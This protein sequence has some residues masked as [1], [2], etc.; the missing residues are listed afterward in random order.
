LTLIFWAI[1]PPIYRQNESTD[2][3]TFYDPIANRLLEG[4]GYT[5]PNG[6]F[7]ARYPPGYPIIL[8]GIYGAAKW[9]TLPK[10]IVLSIFI[11]VV[12]GLTSVVLFL[13]TNEVLGKTSGIIT[14]I[15]WM[16]YP[17]YLWIT[18]QPNSEIIF[19]LFLYTS[20]LIFWISITNK[21]KKWYIF[22]LIGI[23]TGISTLIRPASLGLILIMVFFI[24]L[25]V[26]TDLKNK[27]KVSISLLMGFILI[28]LPWEI[29]I[30][31]NMSKII[32]MS[33]NGPKTI[34]LGLTYAVIDEGFRSSDD[35]QVDED[36]QE[37]MIRYLKKSNEDEL[38]SFGGISKELINETLLH[39]VT[40]SKIFVYKTLRSWYATDSVR[41]ETPIIL[42]QIVY[43]SFILLGAISL[44]IYGGIK[45]FFM[46]FIL[47]IMI[48]FWLI[49]I[50]VISLVRYM[51]PVTGLLFT[52]IPAGRLFLKNKILTAV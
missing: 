21:R 4:K 14:S 37:F 7:S 5:L 3:F 23:I 6:S 50:S 8:A 25:G 47:S 15:L 38:Q 2:F 31:R 17:L 12:V 20:I 32:L 18:K 48:Y 41:W 39:P 33:T 44:W 24:L 51:V 19:I 9:F 26:K 36:V 40:I 43:L 29:S 45:R 28:I 42:I 13:L 49:T 34:N 11:L 16:T 35:Y 52:F 22:V 1:L 27:I 10:E 30:Y 46:L